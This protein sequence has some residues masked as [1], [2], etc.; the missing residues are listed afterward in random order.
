V[1]KPLGLNPSA[2]DPDHDGGNVNLRKIVV[3]GKQNDGTYGT[4][5]GTLYAMLALK[6]MGVTIDPATVA[7]VR[8]AQEASGG[9]DFEGS[10]T[11][12]DADVDTT[13]VAVEA[14]V[15]A[16]VAPTDATEHKGLGFLA[17]QY[18]DTT[19]A[20]QAFGSDDPNSTAS[21]VLAV[22]AAGY[23]PTVRCWRDHSA[24]SLASHAYHSPIVW[25]RS[26][27]LSNGRVK[28]PSDSFGVNTFATT[29]TIEAW[30]RQ[31]L[32]IAT[33]AKQPC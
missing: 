2:F 10:S 30:H 32:P 12:T 3:S 20:W 19:G 6:S 29:Q 27:Q 22:T 11:K 4:F 23:D 7:A 14:L 28:S 31:F 16:G 9:W 1:V 8:T 13:A 21:A 18:H 24:P 33:A 5:N 15:A 17:A 26:Q 25:L